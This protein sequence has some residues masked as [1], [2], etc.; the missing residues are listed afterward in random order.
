M[1]SQSGT[2]GS[3]TDTL[4]LH[5][6]LPISTKTVTGNVAGTVDID[7]AATA[8][9]GPISS[10]SSLSFTVVHAGGAER[11][12]SGLKWSLR[13]GSTGVVSVTIVDLN[14]NT[15]TSGPDSTLSVT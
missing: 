11:V 6:A 5:D 3:V 4:A 13:S 2:T 7:G 9:G 14:G 12:M 15:V 1:L 8:A 10:A